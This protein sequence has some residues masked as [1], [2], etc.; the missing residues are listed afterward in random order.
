VDGKH[1]SAGNR[2]DKELGYI[3]IVEVLAQVEWRLAVIQEGR[4]LLDVEQGGRRLL[5]ATTRWM[6]SRRW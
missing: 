2:G 6:L 5:C 3:G 4:W 1:L